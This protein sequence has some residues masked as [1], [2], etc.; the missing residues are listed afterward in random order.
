M[1]SK[2]RKFIIFYHKSTEFRPIKMCISQT[3]NLLQQHVTELFLNVSTC[4]ISIAVSIMLPS[5]T[6]C[7][8]VSWGGGV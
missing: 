1:F 4:F 7:T 3:L 6:P 5:C 2:L 8:F